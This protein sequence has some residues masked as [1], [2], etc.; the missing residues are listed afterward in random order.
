MTAT[1]SLSSA[2]PLRTLRRPATAS[3]ASRRAAY[4]RAIMPAN[5]VPR[6]P[7]E[8]P[9]RSPV[10]GRSRSR[11]AAAARHS[12]AGAGSPRSRRAAGAPGLQR[13]GQAS[14]RQRTRQHLRHA[15]DRRGQDRGS[16]RHR[17]EQHVRQ[18]LPLRRQQ[19]E[20]GGREHG[21]G[22]FDFAG[23]EDRRRGGPSLSS[24]ARS[25]SLERTGAADH[26]GA[27]GRPCPA[28]PARGRPLA[29]AQQLQDPLRRLLRR[30]PPD[31]GDDRL[32]RRRAPGPRGPPPAA[33]RFPRPT[34]PR[35]RWARRA[36]VAAAASPRCSIHAASASQTQR[37][38]CAS[39]DLT[40]SHRRSHG[41]RA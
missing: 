26:A 24:A 36:G 27:A 12:R 9:A 14:G 38:R 37:V 8:S 3:D 23:P 4:Q 29:G 7:R 21:P 22:I 2:P 39:R 10:R 35:C 19:Q 41:T 25:S 1:I 30:Q 20:V 5:P 40:P 6:T 16:L 34:E 13:P 11:A 17:L 32:V 28:R 31:K 15:P 18:P 33:A